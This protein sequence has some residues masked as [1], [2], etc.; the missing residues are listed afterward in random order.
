VKKETIK[1]V[2]MVR[3][4]R[5]AHYEQLRG[6]P[7]AEWIALYQEKQRQAQALIAATHP[8]RNPVESHPERQ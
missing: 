5:D 6:K 1:A 3:Q 4:I 8:E 2:E 7:A